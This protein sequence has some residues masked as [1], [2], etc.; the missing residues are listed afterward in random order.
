MPNIRRAGKD[1]TLDTLREQPARIFFP[2]EMADARVVNCYDQLTRAVKSG[3]LPK[4]YRV[5][6]RMGW[7]GRDI[8]AMLNASR[9]IGRSG[10]PE[11]SEQPESGDQPAGA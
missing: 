1:I 7:E 6:N 8:L 2:N 3:R 9:R 11:S 5:G 10:K 4:P